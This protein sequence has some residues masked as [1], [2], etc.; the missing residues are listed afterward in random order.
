MFCT[1]CGKKVEDTWVKCPYCG[2]VLQENQKQGNVQQEK[3][4]NTQTRIDANYI[5]NN[6]MPNNQPPK[7]KKKLPFIIGGVAIVVV[8]LFVLLLGGRHDSTPKEAVELSSYEGGF[9]GWEASGFEG[10]VKT[11]IT[12]PYPIEDNGNNYYAVWIGTG[13]I[14]VGIIMQSDEAKVAD[15]E[16][17]QNAQPDIE[18]QAYYFNCTLTY[19][20]QTVGENETPVFVIENAQQSYDSIGNQETTTGLDVSKY[21][22]GDINNL[23][24]ADNHLSTDD[25]DFY[26][27][28]TESVMASVT[29]GS[30]DMFIIDGATDYPVNFAG[31]SVGDSVQNM[32]DTGLVNA[33]YTYYYED[34]GGVVYLYSDNMAGVAF[35]ADEN[36]YIKAIYWMN[37]CAEMLDSGMETD[38]GMSASDVDYGLIY[39][40]ILDGILANLDLGVSSDELQYA[41][42]DI[43]KDGYLEFFI[44]NG[45]LE[46]EVW[47]TTGEGCSYLG[48]INDSRSIGLY[49]NV[50]GNGLYTDYCNMGYE[51]ITLVDS[52]DGVLMETTIFEGENIEEYGYHLDGTPFEELAYPIPIHMLQEGIMW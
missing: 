15:W 11:D 45:R 23:L 10:S 46:Y 21:V 52:E 18:T 41:F 50:N 39:G 30:I 25:G 27:D 2:N 1:K 40:G 3:H 26:A 7:K 44:E 35:Q 17:L 28:A 49:E 6:T 36:G 51:I 34:A 5:S 33:G 14:N 43:D 47:T 8:I 42:Y 29:D 4:I 31:I 48:S 20:K 19:A 22:G 24:Q 16:W 38:N 32:S 9:A 13:K 12:I 37:N